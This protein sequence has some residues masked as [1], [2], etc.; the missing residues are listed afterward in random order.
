VKFGRLNHMFAI[1][2]LGFSGCFLLVSCHITYTVRNQYQELEQLL[3]FPCGKVGLEL[4]GKGNS[5][6]I[7]SQKFDLDSPVTTFPDS[8]RIF[9]NEIPITYTIK[10][11]SKNQSDQSKLVQSERVEIL[12]ETTRGVFDGDRIIIFAPNYMMCNDLIVGFDTISYN[13]TNRLRIY[14]VNAL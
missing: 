14:G 3:H 12:F 13:F 10:N 4:E 7:F 9:F 8:V 2:A 11:K 6:F 5:K 1:F